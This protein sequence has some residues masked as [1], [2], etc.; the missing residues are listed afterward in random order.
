[1]KKASFKCEF[2]FS[3]P[4]VPLLIVLSGPSGA[5]KDAVL[6]RMKQSGYP[7][8]YTTTATTRPKRTAEKDGVD[9]HF[10]SKES[11]KKMLDNKELVESAN[12]YGNWYGIP[13]KPIE[14]ALNKG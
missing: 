11:F 6:N 8:E 1:M 9:Y 12:V 14:Q 13:K 5:G 3:L 7:I 4:E 2:P 10:I